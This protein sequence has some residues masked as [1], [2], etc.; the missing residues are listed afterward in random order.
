MAMS[1]MGLIPVRRGSTGVEQCSDSICRML[2][3]VAFEPAEA[4]QRGLAD[5][6]LFGM[7]LERTRLGAVEVC[8]RYDVAWVDHGF[9]HICR[10]PWSVLLLPKKTRRTR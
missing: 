7:R 4:Q 8:L 5:A 9:I 3:A 10:C 2:L 1:G 6:D